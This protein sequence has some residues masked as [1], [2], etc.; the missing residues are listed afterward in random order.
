MN[1]MKEIDEFMNKWEEKAIAHYVGLN[2]QYQ[3]FKLA[4]KQERAEYRKEHKI[5][6]FMPVPMSMRSKQYKCETDFLNVC[7]ASIGMR[8]LIQYDGGRTTGFEDMIR[9][10]VKQES[11]RKKKNLLI[12]IQKR[13]G[14]IVHA[15]LRI[16]GN[17][18]LNGIIEGK[19]GKVSV[20]TIS[21]GGY[22]I[23]CMHFRVLIKDLGE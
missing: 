13:I 23:Q 12:Q 8:N 15:S 22:N 9:H 17:N 4:H 14:D 5:S 16:G 1:D 20:E 10:L 18:E 11:E 6:E 2:K 3:G 19:E 21:A 7:C